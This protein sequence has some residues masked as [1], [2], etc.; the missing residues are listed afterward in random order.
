MK[1][2]SSRRDRWPPIKSWTT[3]QQ[4]DNQE[5]R[6]G[7]IEALPS[8]TLLQ[9]MRWRPK[10]DG[11]GKSPIIKAVVE[12]LEP[13]LDRD[14]VEHSQAGARCRCNKYELHQI[15]TMRLDSKNR[16]LETSRASTQIWLS[17]TSTMKMKIISTCFIS[18][19]F[20]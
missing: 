18:K 20:S 5:E 11:L 8:L 7:H 13:S 9:L 4:E 2:I 19:T 17:S 15:N 1:M 3:R 6:Q 12:P 16:E 14:R 10:M